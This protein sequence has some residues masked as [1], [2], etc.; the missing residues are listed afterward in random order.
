MK[1]FLMLLLFVSVLMLPQQ[2]MTQEVMDYLI[3]NDVA[4]Y[5]LKRESREFPDRKVRAITPYKIYNS[6]GILGATGHFVYDH[7]DVTYETVYLGGP[8]L[9]APT[10]Q[11]TQHSGSDSDKWLLHEVDKSFRTYY[12]MPGEE[13]EMR[14]IDGNTIMT[15]GSAGWH[16]RWL[17]GNKVIQL[18]Y[19]DSQM[20]KP[21]PLEVVKAYLAK[22]PSTLP[23]ITSADL[24]TSD[25]K[26]KWLKDEMERRLWLSE[27]WFNQ[28]DLQKAELKSVVQEAVKHL[29]VFLKY[30]EKYYGVSAKDDRNLLHMYSSQNNAASLKEKLKEYQLWWSQNKTEPINLP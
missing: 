16:Y 15:F 3:L 23:A 13:Y 2:G 25:S 7:N 24:R 22:H 26:T 29:D 8:N 5:K 19:H 12:G 18:E 20:E 6:A 11:V 1:G 10:V 14:M 21:E 4:P 17:S 30:R 28:L 27:K 9:S